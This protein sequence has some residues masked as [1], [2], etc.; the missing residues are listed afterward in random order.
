MMIPEAEMRILSKMIPFDPDEL[1]AI[2]NWEKGNSEMIFETAALYIEGQQA[3]LD[4]EKKALE[5]ARSEIEAI[6]KSYK[7]RLVVSR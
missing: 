4:D 7:L 2:G 6:R 5:L 1:K 3:K